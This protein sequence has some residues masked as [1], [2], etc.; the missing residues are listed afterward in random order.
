MKSFTYLFLAC[1]LL[2]NVAF[3][4]TAIDGTTFVGPDYSITLPSDWQIDKGQGYDVAGVYVNEQTMEFQTVN[5]VLE[6]IPAGVSED[7]YLQAS[8]DNLRK[9]EEV[10]SVSDPDI[11]KVGKYDAHHF[12][13]TMD[14]GFMVL[15]SDAYVVIQDKAA[16]IIS[17]GTNQ[18]GV[19]SF[20]PVKD[21][22]LASFSIQ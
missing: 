17:C 6:N 2:T 16:Y 22:I 14:L 21:K 9:L 11:V 19:A 12:A 8:V 1:L 4:K 7:M 10:K 15:K 13:Y 20:K 3:S 5:V 18:E